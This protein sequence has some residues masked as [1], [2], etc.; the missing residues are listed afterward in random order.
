[1]PMAEGF[2]PDDGLNS[3]ATNPSTHPPQQ[4]D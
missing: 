4:V 1:M 2:A 3:A